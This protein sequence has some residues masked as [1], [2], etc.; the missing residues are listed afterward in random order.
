MFFVVGSDLGPKSFTPLKADLQSKVSD[1]Y[2]SIILNFSVLLWAP[3]DKPFLSIK[4]L[5]ILLLV[6]KTNDVVNIF[7]IRLLYVLF[8]WY[9]FLHKFILMKV[10]AGSNQCYHSCYSLEI[11][12]FKPN[13]KKSQIHFVSE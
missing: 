4:Y 13:N 12:Y 5:V 3:C 2:F 6:D 7:S 1:T 11:L 10:F 8:V 9:F